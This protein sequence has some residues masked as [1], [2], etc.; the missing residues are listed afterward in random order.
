[1]HKASERD[2]GDRTEPAGNGARSLASVI[3]EVQAMWRQIA[4][5]LKTPHS[6][7]GRFQALIHRT[8][9]DRHKEQWA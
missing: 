6:M 7:T 3:R 9:K 8:G 5:S 2:G 4:S 1:M